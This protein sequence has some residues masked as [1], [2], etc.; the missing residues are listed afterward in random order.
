MGSLSAKAKAIHSA[1]EA[2]DSN[3]EGTIDTVVHWISGSIAAGGKVLIFGNGGSAADSQHFA[4]EL[5]S[6][7]HG[8][9]LPS[10]LRALALTTDTSILTAIGNDADFSQVFARQVHAFCDVDDV[11]IGLSTSG[12]SKNVLQ[13]LRAGAESGA[14]TVAITGVSGLANP[15]ADLEIRIPSADTQVIQSLTLLTLHT[16]CEDLEKLRIRTEQGSAS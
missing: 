8:A 10:P 11:V 15:F 7:L 2:I 1:L 5:V 6:S 13:G 14:R 16:I 9:P 12:R 4:A 3:F